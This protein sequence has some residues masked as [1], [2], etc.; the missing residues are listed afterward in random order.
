MRGLFIKIIIP[1]TIQ[2][3]KCDYKSPLEDKD[4]LNIVDL[5]PECEIFYVTSL[6]HY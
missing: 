2:D 6:A 4:C 3:I 5:H 1:L